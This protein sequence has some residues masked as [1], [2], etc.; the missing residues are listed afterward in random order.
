MSSRDKVRVRIAPSPT[1]F[2]HVGTAR[3]ALFNWLF[4]KKHEG[5]FI[6]RIEDTDR[7]RS[8]PE[9]EESI[10]EGLAWLNLRWDEGPI[11]QSERGKVYQRYLERLLAEKHAY[12]C[13]CTEA[14]LDAQ[15][16]SMASEGM[17]PRYSGR[18]RT[19]SEGEVT[20]RVAANAR[21][22]IRFKMPE[23]A[24]SFTDLIRGKVTFDAALIG[25]TVIAKSPREPLY[26]LAAVIDDH[27][28]RIT[29]VIRGE[30]HLA[31][32]PKQILLGK[33][34]GFSELAYAHLPL[35]LNP[36]RSKM[37]KRFTA[38]AVEE[39]RKAGYLPEAVVNFLAFLGWHPAP[40]VNRE[41]GKVVEREIMSMDEILE[42]FDLS[43]VQKGGAV[44]NLEKLDWLNAQYLK[45]LSGEEFLRAAEKISRIPK[46]I[47]RERILGVVRLVRDRVKKLSEFKELSSY[48]FQLPD[49]DA[50]MIPFKGIS[51][52]ETE[53]NLIASREILRGVN[54]T[55]FIRD[56][57]SEILMPVAE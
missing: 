34:L 44:F 21:S 16:E 39:Y 38:T 15:R 10:V 4:A 24:V 56:R 13:F 57:L 22:V 46:T 11:R 50:A 37:S 49:Y 51:K 14:E 41:T 43:R 12:Y 3:T 30:D 20:A 52:E 28:M 2:L 48:L 54:G 42:R 32:T 33:A 53:K 23:A 18:C 8:R 45:K 26:N 27:E 36:N 31:N 1:G 29:H 6:L 47:P 9:F 35:I 19:L 55:D 25:D 7:E 5:T 17:V 40:E